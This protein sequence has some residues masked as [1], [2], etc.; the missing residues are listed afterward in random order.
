ML[1][2]SLSF[3]LLVF[4]SF[5]LFACKEK[6]ADLVA[7][8]YPHYDILNNIAKDKLK[9]SLISP[10]GGEVHD[11]TPTPKD[12]VMINESKLFVYA[13]NE[14]DT[15]VN[16]LVNTDINIINMSNRV[17]V[18]FSEDRKSVV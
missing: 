12:I 4:I 5:N 17:D 2:K 7:T 14:L 9:V 11:Y 16:E 8:F 10:F 1:R 15:W 18:E 13:S 3:L 6:D